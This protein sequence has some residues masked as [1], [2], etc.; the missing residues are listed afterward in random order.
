MS[1]G[2]NWDAGLK[3]EVKLCKNCA[4]NAGMR[5]EM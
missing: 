3:C 2:K 5:V 1:G 4:R